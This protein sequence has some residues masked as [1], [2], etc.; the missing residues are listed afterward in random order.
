MIIFYFVFVLMLILYFIP[1]SFY[2][3]R[4]DKVEKKFLIKG[5]LQGKMRA[6]NKILQE[7]K[8]P[9]QS[10]NKHVDAIIDPSDWDS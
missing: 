10:F 6:S 7:G 9:T 3:F 1:K 4:R 2:H 5:K 8:V